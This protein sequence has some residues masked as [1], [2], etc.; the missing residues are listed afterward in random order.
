MDALLKALFGSF[1]GS[2]GAFDNFNPEQLLG[3]QFGQQGAQ[4]GTPYGMYGSMF[5]DAAPQSTNVNPL[6]DLAPTSDTYL[7]ALLSGN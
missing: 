2:L 6:K 3:A 5:G 7:K 1:N 4:Q